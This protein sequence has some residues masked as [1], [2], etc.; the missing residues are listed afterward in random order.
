MLANPSIWIGANLIR[1]HNGEKWVLCLR[2]RWSLVRLRKLGI[3]LCFGGYLGL[4]SVVGNFGV[5][6]WRRRR[7][8]FGNWKIARGFES[9]D[10]L[11]RS[12]R[13][14]RPHRSQ[15]RYTH[16]WLTLFQLCISRLGHIDLSCLAGAIVDYE[17]RHTWHNL[18]QNRIH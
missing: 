18:L 7:F 17:W 4:I 14:I 12:L 2:F 9:F 15:V 10:L 16:H 11:L 6:S 3:V 8:K 5:G 1:C 13:S